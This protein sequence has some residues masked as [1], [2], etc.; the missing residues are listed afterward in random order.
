M[1]TNYSKCREWFKW[2]V[3]SRSQEPLLFFFHE[4]V[5]NALLFNDTKVLSRRRQLEN[6]L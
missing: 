2:K 6:I 1:L 4:V 5:C 3:E